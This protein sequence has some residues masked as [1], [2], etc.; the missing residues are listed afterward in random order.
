[1]KKLDFSYNPQTYQMTSGDVIGLEMKATAN[2]TVG[3]MSYVIDYPETLVQIVDVVLP[4]VQG[5]KMYNPSDPNGHLRIAWYSL[6][7]ANLV[8][9]EVFGTIMLKLLRTPISNE[10]IELKMLELPEVEFG[11]QFAISIPDVVIE[12]DKPTQVMTLAGMTT[13]QK[14]EYLAYISKPFIESCGNCS[15]YT[16]ETRKCALGGF[17]VAKAGKCSF[18]TN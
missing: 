13:T 9:G 6:V 15:N 16:V 12:I 17:I 18:Y 14:K 8:T 5:G 11:N 7:P 3:A 10:A 1:M 4:A 2:L